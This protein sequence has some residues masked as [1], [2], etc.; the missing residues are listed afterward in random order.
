MI[1]HGPALDLKAMDRE[2]APLFTKFILQPRSSGFL[3]F[4]E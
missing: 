4:I 2:K 1:V 3:K